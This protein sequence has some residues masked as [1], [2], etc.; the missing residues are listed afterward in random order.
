MSWIANDKPSPRLLRIALVVTP[1]LLLA[2]VGSAAHANIPSNEDGLIAFQRGGDANGQV[3][4]M[5]PSSGSPEATAVQVTTGP[6]PEAQP[7]YGP[8]PNGKD[9][10]LASQRLT[11]GSWDIWSRPTRGTRGMVP[12][13][14][15]AA[16]L[17]VGPGNQTAPAYSRLQDGKS[18]LAYVSDQ[19]GRAEIWLRDGAGTLTQLTTDGAGYANP[20]FAGRFRAFDPDADG[21]IDSFRIGL[22][23]ESTHGARR[24]IWALEIEVDPNVAFM[25]VHDLRPIASGPEDLFAPSW[26]TTNDIEPGVG[27]VYSRVNEILFTTAQAGNSY[28]DYVEE[29]WSQ[30]AEGLVMPA[31]PFA[32]PAAFPR[33]LLTGN[34]GGDGAAVWAPNGDQVAVGRTTL[35][36]SDIWAMLSNGTNLRRLTTGP[37]PELNPSWQPGSESTVDKVGGHTR[38]G[39]VDRTREETP[40]PPPPVAAQPLRP[41]AP[42]QRVSPQ[43]RK[44]SV[45]W[46]AGKVRVTGRSA[47]LA[48]RLRVTF[49]CGPRPSQRKVTSAPARTGRFKATFRAPPACRRARRATLVVT[50]RGD[51]TYTPQRASRR[52]RRR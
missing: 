7:A 26:Q 2:L 36:N 37:S 17:V 30:N 23:F 43:L 10:I 20:D 11:G 9:W 21:T 45:R 40:Q 1:T 18:L 52:V 35:G 24:A 41:P 42:R 22:A 6:E 5:D 25:G 39:P 12:Q 46:R 15:P 38:P 13:F 14:D 34:P 4:V 49:K 29:P 19:T 3:W 27:T 28:L 50:Y 51:S 48:R 31:V 8:T 47:P 16:P 44:V 32:N 33:F